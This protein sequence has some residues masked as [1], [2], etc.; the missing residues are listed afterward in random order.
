MYYL[1]E[2]YLV[3]WARSGFQ[4]LRKDDAPSWLDQLKQQGLTGNFSSIDEHDITQMALSLNR[5]VQYH[6]HGGRI[7]GGGSVPTVAMVE[8]IV[9]H[10]ECRTYWDLRLSLPQIGHTLIEE[11]ERQDRVLE[12]IS[13]HF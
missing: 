11:T 6:R 10:R 2:I 7:G 5:K 12:I 8:S 1:A 4:G 3:V 9:P 13:G